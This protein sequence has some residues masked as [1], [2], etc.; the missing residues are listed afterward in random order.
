MGAL[1]RPLCRF[2]WSRRQTDG[3]P[4]PDKDAEEGGGGSLASTEWSPVSNSHQR[5]YMQIVGG[6]RPPLQKIAVSKTLP[7]KGSAE[8][9]E[10][11]RSM[12]EAASVPSRS[13]CMERS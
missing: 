13:A 8:Y 1:R 9:L 11:S 5:A 3:L 6:H 7:Q 2:D 12:P 10:R 4:G